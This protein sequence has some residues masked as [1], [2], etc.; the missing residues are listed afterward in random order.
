MRFCG[1]INSPQNS[2]HTHY[3]EQPKAIGKLLQC[4]ARTLVGTFYN[5]LCTLK[6]DARFKDRKINLS[7]LCVS[8]RLLFNVPY[9]ILQPF[10]IIE[11]FIGFSFHALPRVYIMDT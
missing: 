10:A 1:R 6:S 4:N 8:M 2:G 5:V 11:R 7:C 9:V 3:S